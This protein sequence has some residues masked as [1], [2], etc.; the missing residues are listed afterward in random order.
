M[1]TKRIVEIKLE[2]KSKAAKDQLFKAFGKFFEQEKIKNH[3]HF[4]KEKGYIKIIH[5]ESRM[6]KLEKSLHRWKKYVF[7]RGAF[8]GVAFDYK[9]KPYKEPEGDL[10]EWTKD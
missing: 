6:K 3:A 5:R 10:G 7:F 1:V 2:W 9:G 8:C 4:D